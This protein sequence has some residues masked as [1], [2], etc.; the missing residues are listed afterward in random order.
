[1]NYYFFLLYKDQ[2]NN[3]ERNILLFMA[4]TKLIYFTTYLW[5]CDIYSQ[6]VTV[7][8]TL[9]IIIII[10]KMILYVL[11]TQV[12][13]PTMLLLLHKWPWED[14]NNYLNHQDTKK[15]TSF[16]MDMTWQNRV[17][18][19][20]YV[21]L[22]NIFYFHTV[23]YTCKLISSWINCSRVSINVYKSICKSTNTK[24]DNIQFVEQIFVKICFESIFSHTL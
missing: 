22:L 7:Y 6:S 20:N 19:R 13:E 24:K 11:N 18:Y 8:S 4:A 5:A 10:T 23:S 21:L 16:R 1:M 15:N 17:F 3:R 12:V 2:L 14:R 9:T